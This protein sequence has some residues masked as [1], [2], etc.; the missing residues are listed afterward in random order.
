MLDFLGLPP[1]ASAHGADIDNMIG[2]VH[3]LMFALFIGWGIFF[4]YVLIRFRRT[5]HQKADY[6][7][8]KTHASTYLEIAVAVFEGILIIGFA[9]PLW[10]QRVNEF[11]EDKDAIVVRVVA[12]QFAWNVHYP[13]ADGFFG[14]T[15]VNLVSADNPIGLDRSDPDGKD[16][17]VTI[18]QLVVPVGKP[19]I[20]RLTSKDVI[21]SFSIPLLRVKQD[22]IP[23]QV[24]PVW[25]EPIETTEHIR[26]AMTKTYSL[27]NPGVNLMTMMTMQDY[28]DKDSVVIVPA[29][30]ILFP[31]VVEQLV[32]SGYTEV[33]AAP[34]TPMEIACAQLC[35]LGHYRMRGFVSVKTPE[36]YEAWLAEEALYLQ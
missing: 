22:V 31:D 13:G 32:A 28:V 24:I 35:G 20:V 26:V 21:H 10:A 19:V 23:G 2:V 12:E 27:I 18:N 34:E 7:G 30:S 5:R 29:G 15:D 11:P 36:A 25:F 3:W 1:D 17:I 9:V 4:T 8:A 33:R 16:D 14:A 6:Q